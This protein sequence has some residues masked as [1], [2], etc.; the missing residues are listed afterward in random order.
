MFE[1][2]IAHLSRHYHVISLAELVRKA[3]IQERL[4]PYTLVIALE[5]GLRSHATVAVRILQKYRL[6][7]TIFLTTAFIGAPQRGLW[8]DRLDWLVQSA[9]QPAVDL[10]FDGAA[11]SLALATVRDRI[12]ASDVLREYLRKL[13]LQLREAKLAKLAKKIGSEGKDELHRHERH[14][15][16]TWDELRALRNK[17]IDFGSHTHTR[18]LMS[19][20]SP[21][22]AH[23]ELSRS[24]QLIQSELDCACEFFSYPRDTLPETR[25]RDSDLLKKLG[26]RAALSPHHGFNR[27]GT[28]LYALR[29]M[30]IGQCPDFNFF[31]AKITG[32]GFLLRKLLGNL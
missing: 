22:E 12:I 20:L 18:A 15:Y 25:T 30:H 17:L 1:R 19:T 6:P 21:A 24:Q 27:S 4:S 9:H 14:A 31:L 13:P 29:R 32:M 3:A 8:T 23:Y 28:D 16:L 10:D 11:R 2:Q 5:D 26:F 7:A